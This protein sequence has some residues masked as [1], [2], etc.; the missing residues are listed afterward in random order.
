MADAWNKN[1]VLFTL[2]AVLQQYLDTVVRVAI[3]RWRVLRL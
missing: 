1:A 3:V 2:A